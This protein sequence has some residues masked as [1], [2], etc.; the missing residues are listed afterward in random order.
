M[1]YKEKNKSC[2]GVIFKKTKESKETEFLI[3]QQNAGGHWSLPK[4]H[5]ERDESERETARREIREETNLEVEFIQGF[6]ET[7]NYFDET[8]KK[9]KEVVFFLCKAKT[10][11]VKIQPEEIKNHA[12]LKYEDAKKRL[13]Y[14]DTKNILMKAKEFLNKN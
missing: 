2:G 8:N 3:L 12:W 10:E 5:V 7:T 9:D 13:T 1:N 4:G 11:N 6:R 14:D